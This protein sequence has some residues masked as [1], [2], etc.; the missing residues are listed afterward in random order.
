[1]VRILPN[2]LMPTERERKVRKAKSMTIGVALHCSDGIVL[3]AD[4]Q[5]TKG[6]LKFYECKITGLSVGNCSLAVTYS[7]SRELM[8]FIWDRMFNADRLAEVRA[9]SEIRRIFEDTIQEAYKSYPEADAEILLAVS[10]NPHE[11]EDDWGLELLKATRHGVREIVDFECIGI[12]DSSLVRYLI[13]IIGKE[14]PEVQEGAA[15]AAYLV[16]QA[17]QYIDGCGGDTDLMI[18]RNGKEPEFRLVKS[19]EERFKLSEEGMAKAFWKGVTR[20]TSQK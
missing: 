11:P 6:D 9:F 14:Q 17:K 8:G 18:I 2:R 1:M 3:C 5:L 12:G 19:M 20:S 15:L 4:R 7:N 10:L 16:K 13:G